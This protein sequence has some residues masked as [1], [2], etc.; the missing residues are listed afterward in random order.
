MLFNP[1]MT[2]ANKLMAKVQEKVNACTELSRS[3]RSSHLLSFNSHTAGQRIAAQQFIGKQSVSLA[4]IKGS[5]NT[6]RS[7][8]F[9]ANFQ[10]VS[11]HSQERLQ[12]VAKAWRTKNLSPISLVQVGDIYFV[13]DG[14]HRVSIAAAQ[15]Q[16]HIA[17]TVTV[18]QLTPIANPSVNNASPQSAF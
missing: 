16:T 4:H 18:L 14:H 7:R 8:D 10:L 3:G 2:T 13:Q 12:N 1:I 11:A 6:S 5:M 17:A 15:G 9:D